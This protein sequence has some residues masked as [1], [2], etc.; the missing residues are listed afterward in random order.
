MKGQERKAAIAAYNERKRAAGIYAVRCTVTGRR[1]VGAAPDLATI[2]NR[3]NFTLRMG[4]SMCRSLQ[5]EWKAH[6]VDAF[7][8]EV[9]E[10]LDEEEIAY[11]R[12]RRLKARAEHWRA[13]L[14]AEAV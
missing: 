3:L 6:G 5:A 1:W 7:A 13:A 14:H 9:L 11:V 12:D 2:W 4:S 10:T 8:F